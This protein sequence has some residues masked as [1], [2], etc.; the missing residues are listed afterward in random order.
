MSPQW[1][2]DVARAMA[3]LK[4]GMDAV[5]AQNVFATIEP[6]A[7][8]DEI[9]YK[10]KIV[11]EFHLASAKQRIYLNVNYYQ[12][13]QNQTRHKAALLF[14]APLGDYRGNVAKL[15]K[16]GLVDKYTYSQWEPVPVLDIKAESEIGPKL[17][18]KI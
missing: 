9:D 8:M 13:G 12:L 3:K 4:V 5:Q 14:K 16:W 6:K 17:K 2:K 1:D 10:S 11:Q 7:K 15:V 18:F